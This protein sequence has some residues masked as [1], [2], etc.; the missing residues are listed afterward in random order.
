MLR[1]S[2]VYIEGGKAVFNHFP[3]TFSAGLATTRGR[4][5][6]RLPTKGWLEGWSNQTGPRLPAGTCSE[7]GQSNTV[8]NY[9]VGPLAQS[10]IKPVLLALRQP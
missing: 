3:V 2:N 5:K 10:F 9:M 6:K 7:N 4:P 1:S 8:I